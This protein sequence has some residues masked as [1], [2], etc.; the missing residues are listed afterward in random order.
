M[1]Q[2]ESQLGLHEHSKGVASGIAAMWERP[3][4]AEVATR[5]NDR[6]EEHKHYSFLTHMMCIGSVGRRMPH[7]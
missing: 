2:S 6:E 1:Q 4:C 5:R 7:S 3:A